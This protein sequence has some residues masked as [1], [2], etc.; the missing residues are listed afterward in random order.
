MDR[1]HCYRLLKQPHVGTLNAMASTLVGTHDF[2]TF[3]AVG[4]SSNTT[5]RDVH[6]ASFHVTGAYIEFRISANA[7][8][9][10][11]VRSIVGTLLEAA[12]EGEG[13][14]HIRSLLDARDRSRAGT[15]APGRGLYLH[16]V[17]YDGVRL[18]A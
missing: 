11:M 14:D 6:A 7:F 1:N 8:L 15:T 12:E 10:K 4:D 13:R 3:A 9:W 5:V 17:A 2:A 16:H 18:H